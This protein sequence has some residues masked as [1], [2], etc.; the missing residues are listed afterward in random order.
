MVLAVVATGALVSVAYV[1]QE[2]GTSGGHMVSA[3]KK[4]L[5][6]LTEDQR[7]RTAF[8]F[9]S[10][11]RTNWNFVPLQ[12]K[13]KKYMRKGLPLEQM[14]TEQQEAARSILR[15]GTSEAGFSK[16]TTIMSLENI[17]ADLEKQRGPVRNPERYF[18]TLFGT[19]S[20]TG[21][22]GWRVEGH[23]LSLNFTL[24]GDKVIGSTPAFFGAN[25]A[26]VMQG[27]RKGLRTLPEAEDLAKDLFKS[28]DERQRTVAYQEKPFPEIEQG[29]PAPRVAE[30]KGLAAAKMKAPQRTKLE[31]LLQSYADRMPADISQAEMNQ[32]REAGLDRVYF[33]YTGGVESGE[34]YTYRI[35]GPTFVVEFLNVQDDS[36]SNPANHIHSAWRN[37]QND[38]GRANR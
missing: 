4:F 20:R 14:T 9:D 37:I 32:V 29:Q 13:Q 18:F 27:D 19:P 24:D 31:Q 33:A 38:F 5:D 28:L 30:P 16:A 35:H 22:W 11:E 36:A 25:P 21:K 26:T 2:K 3:A 7:T 1:G 34:P 8:A 6:S 12:D 10:K 17:L 15:A 23:H